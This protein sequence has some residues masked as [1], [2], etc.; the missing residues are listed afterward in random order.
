MPKHFSHLT[1][2]LKTGLN[3]IFFSA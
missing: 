1:D 3:E 2:T